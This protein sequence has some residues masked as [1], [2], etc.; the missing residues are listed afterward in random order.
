MSLYTEAENLK[1]KTHG[2]GHGTLAFNSFARV[3]C[4]VLKKMLY[5]CT[6]F[7]LSSKWLIFLHGVILVKSLVYFTLLTCRAN[8]T[9]ALFPMPAGK[10]LRVL[11]T[12]AP[13]RVLSPTPCD[14]RTTS[15]PPFSLSWQRQR[16]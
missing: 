11:H 3:N 10:K 13:S 8:T 4:A 9:I 15:A 14:M 6:C 2:N 5:T 16:T 7:Y 12:I 1:K